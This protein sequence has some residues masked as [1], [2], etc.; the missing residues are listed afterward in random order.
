MRKLNSSTLLIVADAGRCRLFALNEAAQLNE[1]ECMLNA[2]ARQAENELMMDKPGRSQDSSGTGRHAKASRTNAKT[3][4]TEVFAKRVAGNIR[5]L[6]D[7]YQFLIVVAAPAFLGLLR[8]AFD[9]TT[10]AKV[11]LE[12][13]KDL[14]HFNPLEIHCSVNEALGKS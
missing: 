10:C 1:L 13:D 14:S 9:S 4:A 11:Y 12:I 2:E 5:T 6:Q 8:A 3:H 7:Q